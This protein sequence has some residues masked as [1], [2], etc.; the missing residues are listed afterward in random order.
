MPI[1]LGYGKL[2]IERGDAAGGHS[3][4][5]AALD[6]SREFLQRP[7][8]AAEANWVWDRRPVSI[9]FRHGASYLAPAAETCERT[10]RR[11]WALAR[12]SLALALL[13][14]GEAARHWPS[15]GRRCRGRIGRSAHGRAVHHLSRQCRGSRGPR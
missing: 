12:G 9:R 3:H 6:L 2:C 10:D 8:L 7:M 11:L 13:G 1:R 14:Q 15:P 5:E 4:Y